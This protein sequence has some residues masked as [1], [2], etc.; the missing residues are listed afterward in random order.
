MNQ[1]IFDLAKKINGYGKITAYELKCQNYYKG[2]DFWMRIVGWIKSLIEQISKDMAQFSTYTSFSYDSLIEPFKEIIKAAENADYVL[3]ADIIELQ[4]LPIIESI[5]LS[6]I[7]QSMANDN[8]GEIVSKDEMLQTIKA[9]LLIIEEYDKALADNIRK[10]HKPD[11]GY[12]PEFTGAGDVTLRIE[13]NEKGFYMAGNNSILYDSYIQAE[14]FYDIEKSKY[15]IFGLGMHFIADFLAYK[16]CEQ[17][18][19]YESDI[20]VIRAYL[21]YVKLEKKYYENGIIKIHYD[22]DITKFAKAQKECDLEETKIIFYKPSIENIDNKALKLQFEKTFMIDASINNQLGL[23]NSN[24]KSNI[25]LIDKNVDELGE[26]FLNKDI[27]IIAAG[28]SLDKNIKQLLNKPKNS[29]ILSTGTVFKKL[30]K[31]GIDIDYVIISDT[32]PKLTSQ[33]HG[34]EDN[35]TP[36]LILSTASKHFA[37]IYAGEKYLILQKDYYASQKLAYETGHNLY[38]SGGSVTTTALDISIRL[39]AKRIIFLGL[40]LAYTDNF[41]HAKDTSLREVS[42]TQGLIPVEDINGK[43]IYSSLNFITY[44]EWIEERIKDIKNVEIIDASEGGAKI[45]GTRICK[46]KEIL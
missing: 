6:C 28:P 33:I 25:R 19:I 39:G 45:A 4:L 36:I 34:V 18:D 26:K 9:N 24:F 17:V 8:N 27:Y 2:M 41:A 46:L 44:K 10:N 23:M 20:N 40:D 5:I 29:I 31:L 14:R 3:M 15:I 35:M 38:E 1:E 7:S 32:N 42:N 11:K 21:S 16:D 37:K 22:P 43:I 12:Y 13:K 30:L